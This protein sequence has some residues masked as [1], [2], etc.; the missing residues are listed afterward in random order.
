MEQD[1]KQVAI[2]LGGIIV[3][4]E[5]IKKLKNRGYY[6]ILIDYFD[7]PPAAEFA[8]EHSKESALDY[9]KVLEIAKNRNANLV[10]SSCLDQQLVVAMKVSEELGLPHPFSSKTATEV[11]NK[12]YMKKIMIDN[13][14]KTSRYYQVN[15]ETDLQKID[16]EYPLIVKPTDSCGSAGVCK[17]E[18]EEEL[19]EAVENACKWS[20]TKEAIVEEYKEGMEVS[21]YSYIKDG[22]ASVVTTSHR[23]SVIEK[24]KVR[25]FCAV[26]PAN[27]NEKALNNMERI[28]NQI[29]QVFNLDNTPLFYQSIVKGDEVN[30]IEFSP[31]LGGGLCYRTMQLNAKFDM[32][33]ASIDSYFGISTD[34]MPKNEET[35]YLIHQIYGNDGVYDHLEGY[36][37]LLEEKI[38]EEIFFHKTKGM[39]IS[40]EKSSSARTAVMLIEGKTSEEYI[41]K[42]QKA[43]DNLEIRDPEGKPLMDKRLYL[44]KTILEAKENASSVI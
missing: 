7:N 13:G 36:E 28:S 18:S 6:T 42:L 31:R 38:I 8:D 22:K 9:D 21:V 44:N 40:N 17:I 4:G 12:K 33:D 32:L 2:V 15:R 34:D 19:S 20:W 37:E 41:D 23:I 27:V 25:C 43:I 24:D 35:Y 30:V 26:S 3:H 14:I 5:L 16:L 39:N 1:N 10:I 29:A 11:T